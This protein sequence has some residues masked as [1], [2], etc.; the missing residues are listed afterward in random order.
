MKTLRALEKSIIIVGCLLLLAEPSLF[1]WLPSP[2]LLLG[3]LTINTI[4]CYVC[5]VRLRDRVTERKSLGANL[6][7]ALLVCH[8]LSQASALLIGLKL[9]NPSQSLSHE[10]LLVSVMLNVTLL[11]GAALSFGCGLLSRKV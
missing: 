1:L 11:G 6:I 7:P 10:S 9:A 5:G 8:L 2:R 3:V 4:A